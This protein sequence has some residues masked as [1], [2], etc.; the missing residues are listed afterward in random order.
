M[1]PAR[2]L[3]I[4]GLQ[5][6]VGRK[7]E[8]EYFL[9]GEPFSRTVTITRVYPPGESGA[10]ALIDTKEKGGTFIWPDQNVSEKKSWFSR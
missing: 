10:V 5:S 1:P 6:L 2:E 3:G 4:E 8:L 7:V 9:Y